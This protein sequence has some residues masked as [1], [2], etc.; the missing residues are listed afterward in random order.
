MILTG[1]EA[2]ALIDISVV[3]THHSYSDLLAV[4]ELA[5]QYRFINV[6]ALPCWVSALDRKSVV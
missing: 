6:H 5:K 3:R 4:V 1:K 2:A